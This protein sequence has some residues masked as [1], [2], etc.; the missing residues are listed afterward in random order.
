MRETILSAAQQQAHI[1]IPTTWG[2]GRATYG[3][4]VAALLLARLIGVVGQ[5]RVL[6]SVTVSF[7]GPVTVGAAELRAEVLRTGQSVIQA[8][9]RLIQA[10]QVQAVLLASFGQ[11][12]E[13]GIVVAPV[14][15]APVLKRAEDLPQMPYIA[16]VMPEF[17]QHLDVRWAEGALPFS[18]ASEPNFAGW[19]RYQQPS[20]TFGVADV[21][22]LIDSWPPAVLPLYRAPAPASSLCWTVEF[23]DFPSHM[24][25][26]DYWQYQVRTDAAAAGYAHTEAHIWSASGQLVAIS[27]QTVAIFA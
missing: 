13:S 16:G 7:V 15:V 17:L 3:G 2:Q 23:I 25:S 14:H 11:A 27:R 19:M 4:L 8:E 10:G 24:S 18:G 21:L 1:E 12:R 6:R 5:D 9:A 22:G 20:V 26:A